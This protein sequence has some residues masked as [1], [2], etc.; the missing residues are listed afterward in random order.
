MPVV[1][2]LP[3]DNGLRGN[4][5]G[6]P[7]LRY[8]SHKVSGNAMKSF[9]AVIETGRDAYWAYLPE[10]PGCVAAGSTLDEVKSLL[11]AACKEYLRVT[12]KGPGHLGDSQD[13]DSELNL[14]F[15]M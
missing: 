12:I 9:L 2:E 6:T 7:P 1:A 5:M 3:Y 13:D 10:I 14:D 11:A 4:S 15:L 8:T